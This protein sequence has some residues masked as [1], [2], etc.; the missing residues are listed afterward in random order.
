MG[1]IG[2]VVKLGMPFSLADTT[3]SRVPPSNASTYADRP[4]AN[5]MPQFTYRS[6]M[7]WLA[8]PEE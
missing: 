3:L 6:T 2:Y 1:V 8:A 7:Y 5:F 4:V